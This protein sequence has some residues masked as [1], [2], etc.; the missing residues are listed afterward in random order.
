MIRMKVIGLD[1]GELMYR[2]ESKQLSVNNISFSYYKNF[3]RNEILKNISFDV[4]S[5][6]IVGIAG[7]SG[8]GKTTLGKIISNYFKNSNLFNYELNGEVNFEGVNVLSKKYIDSN[9][10]PPIQMIFQEPKKS[11]NKHVSLRSQL[12]ATLKLSNRTISEESI[13]IQI[14]NYADEF[15]FSD[16]LDKTPEDISGGQ[17]RRF[18][19]ARILSL[20][21]KLI[22]ADE[23]V[24]SLDTSIKNEIL[25]LLFK[26]V[27]KNITIIMISHDISLLNQYANKI[28]ILD[29]GE[30]IDQ[31]LPKINEFPQSK[32]GK[33]LVQDAQFVNSILTKL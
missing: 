16:L 18:G 32:H 12:A 28:L 23:P 13:A 20:N 6:S 26:L 4:L 17:R 22:I 11:L 10:I 27:N 3:E 25:D 5:N 2:L 9:R 31:W 14:Q 8:C 24:A 19:I 7:K 30:L 21:P 15:F 29:N 1:V 33:E